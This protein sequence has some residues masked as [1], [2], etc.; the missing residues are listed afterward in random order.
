MQKRFDLA[1]EAINFLEGHRL[2][3]TTT[4][5]GFAL[6]V[7]SNRRSSLAQAVERETEGGLRLTA[8]AVVELQSRYSRLAGGGE[9]SLREQ[10]VTKHAEQLDALTSDAHDLTKNLGLD[11]GAMAHKATEWPNAV[12][13]VGRL[14]GAERELSELRSEFAKLREEVVAS[15]PRSDINR[16]DMT[17]ALNQQGAIP[18]FQ[19]LAAGNR[20][21]VVILF[22]V[23]SLVSINSRFGREVGDNVLNAFAAT[24]R[25]VFDEEELIRW[26]GTEFVIPIPSISISAARILAEEALSKFHARRLKLRGSGDWIGTISASAGIVADRSNEPAVV[27]H[28]A[29]AYAL[30]AAGEGGNRVYS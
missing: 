19:R 26:S 11:V 28:K 16:D 5:Y 7:V 4:H 1:R 10:S 17:Q 15:L 25:Q 20:P 12:D 24:L 22:I 8:E 27:V 29:Q 2:H 6:E 30:T 18:V 3:P 13:L 9:V 21:Y 23:D 14:S